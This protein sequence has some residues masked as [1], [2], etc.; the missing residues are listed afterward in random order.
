LQ[1]CLEGLIFVAM[2]EGYDDTQLNKVMPLFYYYM[3]I[4]HNEYVNNYYYEIGGLSSVNEGKLKFMWELQDV[5]TRLEK[6]CADCATD[7]SDC[8]CS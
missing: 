7:I 8:G 3:A 2:C 1:E 6:Y 5:A 4:L